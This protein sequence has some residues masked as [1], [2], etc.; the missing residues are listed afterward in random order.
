MPSFLQYA[1]SAGVWA[2]AA[3]GNTSAA[4]T[5]RR[6]NVV[7]ISL[8]FPS[9]SWWTSSETVQRGHLRTR[10]RIDALVCLP[11]AGYAYSAANEIGRSAG[12]PPIS[13]DSHRG[14]LKIY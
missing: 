13:S 8:S 11:A 4:P 9:Y 2:E 3:T 10:W 6:V 1:T 12:W 5:A 7:F 14:C